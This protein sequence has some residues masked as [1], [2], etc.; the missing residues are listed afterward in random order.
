VK[1]LHPYLLLDL[2]D[3]HIWSLHLMT[4]VFDHLI[5]VFQVLSLLMILM[6]HLL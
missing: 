3:D 6:L 4:A 1:I 5:L 2:F